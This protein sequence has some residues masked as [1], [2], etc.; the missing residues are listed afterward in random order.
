MTTLPPPDGVDGDVND[1]IPVLD[2]DDIE[3]DTRDDEERR[4]SAIAAVRGALYTARRV[5]VLTGAGVSAASGV[6]TF[7]G[8]GGLWR[9][10]RPE[11][12]ATP[13]AF[14]LEPGAVWGF[15]HWRRRLLA[16]CTCNAAHEA[17]AR[18]EEHI[19]ECACITQ[20]VDGLHQAAGSRNV[21]E[22]HGNIWRMR[23]PTCCARYEDR[24]PDLD[25]LPSCRHCGALVR[26]D[27][28]WFGEPLDPD[29]LMRAMGAVS[30]CHVLLVVGTAAQVHPAAT[31]PREA[32]A[33]G[34]VV[35][36]INTDP[37]PLT[38]QADFVLSGKAADVLHRL[39]STDK[40]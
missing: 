36:E 25:A 23:C 24:S 11:E 34:A 9:N 35:V 27:V 30:R 17:I 19:P 28:V 18:L 26:P 2:K 10:R 8:T 1:D 20:N 32:K 33:A 22:L 13:Q 16:R 15:Y 38:A 4:E 37:T 3:D 6:P 29:V 21:I 12:L 40:P 5:V 7:R 39:V 14:A 31:L